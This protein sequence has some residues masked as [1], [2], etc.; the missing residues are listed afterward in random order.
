L[1]P[2]HSHRVGAFGLA[3]L[4]ACAALPVSAQGLVRLDTSASPRLQQ[5][6]N[7]VTDENGRAFASNP[8]AR[9]AVARFGRVE[10]RLAT[11]DFVGRRVK[12]YLQMPLPPPGVLNREGLK[13]RWQGL[14]G[15]LDGEAVLGQR[16][17]VWSGVVSGPLHNI[18]F[19]LSMVVEVAQID[20]RFNG[21]LG[22]EPIFYLE[23][24]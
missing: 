19:D 20:G 9:Q 23:P 18:A 14:D 17:L 11:A 16:A 6:T 5:T 4:M 13:A 8:L 22:F 24:L 3:V 21:P 15:A 12:I 7:V 2:P 10:H 1:A